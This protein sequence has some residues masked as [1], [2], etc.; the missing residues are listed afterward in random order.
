M[1]CK[2]VLTRVLLLFLA[3]TFLLNSFT[4]ELT[5]HGKECWPVPLYIQ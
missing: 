1:F 4:L 5:G 3:I 2:Q